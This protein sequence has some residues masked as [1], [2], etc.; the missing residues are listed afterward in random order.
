M[1]EFAFTLRKTCLSRWAAPHQARR[2]LQFFAIA[3]HY[4]ADLYTCSCVKT[5]KL[6]HGIHLSHNRC[7]RLNHTLTKTSFAFSGGYPGNVRH[8]EGAL[9]CT[10]APDLRCILQ[11]AMAN[12]KSSVARPSVYHTAR[13]TSQPEVQSSR[14]RNAS[15]N[16]TTL[17]ER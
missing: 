7:A 11:Y 10:Y 12:G 16:R 4:T 15:P 3:S 8:R 1:L 2:P 17:P 9:A 14:L 13:S 5:A 6:W